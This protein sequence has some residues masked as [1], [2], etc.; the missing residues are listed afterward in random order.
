MK[1]IYSDQLH[2]KL[3]TSLAVALTAA[4]EHFETSES[5][6]TRLALRQY[7]KIKMDGLG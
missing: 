4:A 5:E 3:P 7:L 2:V 6:I 1:K